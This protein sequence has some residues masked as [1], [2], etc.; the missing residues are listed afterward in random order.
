MSKEDQLLRVEPAAQTVSI[1]KVKRLREELCILIED[2]W[3]VDRLNEIGNYTLARNLLDMIF[4]ED[5]KQSDKE[6]K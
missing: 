5:L 6:S 1:D 2:P 4:H 3:R